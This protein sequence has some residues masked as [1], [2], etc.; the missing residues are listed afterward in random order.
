MDIVCVGFGPAAG[1]FLTTLARQLPLPD[2]TMPQVICYE[3]ADDIGFGVSGVVTCARAIRE[4]F[5]QFDSSQIPTCAPVKQEKVIY[6]LDPV[7]ASR[8]STTVRVTDKML[9]FCFGKNF[10]IEFPY[11]PPYLQK[12]GGFVT[13]IGQFNQWVGS[14]LMSTGAVQIWPGTPAAE[15]LIVDDKVNGV[16]L[17]DILDWHFY[18]SWPRGKANDPAAMEAFWLLTMLAYILFHAFIGRN[19]KPVFRHRHTKRHLAEL[20]TAEIYQ[21]AGIGTAPPL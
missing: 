19:L 11:I 15:P 16:R 7:G 1:G 6:L 3:R 13:S 4:S 14:Q 21:C 17:V 9:R 18:P 12:H 20:I 5:P 8:R 10:A 2:G